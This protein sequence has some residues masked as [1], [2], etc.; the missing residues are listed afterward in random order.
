M[1]SR[2]FC[3]SRNLA[4]L[5]L[6]LVLLPGLAGCKKPSTALM[7]LKSGEHWAY[8]VRNARQSLVGDVDVARQVAVDGVM[9][10]ELHGPSGIS[11]L[12]W[13]NGT[14]VASILSGTRY[15]PPLVLVIPNS[16]GKTLNWKGT[17]FT[18]LHSFPA[19][20]TMTWQSQD[21]QLGGKIFHT[22][23]QNCQLNLSSGTQIALT[24]WFSSQ[25]GIVRQ[26]QRTNGVQVL[27]LERLSGP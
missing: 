8:V 7:P 19:V 15:S 2:S 20:A 25:V 6:I 13:K 1:N 10:W 23:R 18:P 24:T 17:V 9:G 12:A 27:A 21:V 26:E 16:V 14:L 11:R 4:V 3:N 22:V 5:P